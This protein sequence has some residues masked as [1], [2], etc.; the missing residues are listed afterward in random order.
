[1]PFW[2]SFHKVG[3]AWLRLADTGSRL[4]GLRQQAAW[5]LRQSHYWLALPGRRDLTPQVAPAGQTGLLGLQL[6][7][8]LAQ[9]GSGPLEGRTRPWIPQ[10]SKTAALAAQRDCC[11]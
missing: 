9:M 3:A 8:L 2:R 1:M 4:Q 6:D 5:L 10:A 11:L 7:Y